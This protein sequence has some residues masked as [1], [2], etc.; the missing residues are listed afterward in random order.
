[1]GDI[2]LAPPL[3]D[4]TVERLKAGDRVFISGDIYTARDTAHKRLVE[5][6]VRGEP[7]P[8]PLNGQIIYYTGPTPAPPGKPIGS[9]GPTTSSRMDAYTPRLLQEGLK[10]TIGKGA[11]SPEVITAL[12][13]YCAVYCAAI[14]GAGAL[15]AKCVKKAEVIAYGDLGPE[16]VMRLTVDRMPVIVI[17]DV[18]GNDLY[19]QVIAAAAP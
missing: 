1:M 5:L 3:T 13:Q 14:G 10:L 6:L 18:Y 9:C 2:L 17:N 19:R 15:I 12:K 4:E 16:A 11:R 8:F 7:L